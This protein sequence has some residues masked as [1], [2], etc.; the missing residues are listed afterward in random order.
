MEIG[1]LAFGYRNRNGE[2]RESFALFGSENSAAARYA[3]KNG[4]PFEPVEIDEASILEHLRENPAEGGAEARLSY[5]MVFGDRCLARVVLTANG[6]S[7]S[8]LGW[9]WLGVENIKSFKVDDYQ[10]WG[11]A[12][13]LRP[14]SKGQYNV[15]ELDDNGN[16]IISFCG[17]M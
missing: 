1:D 10:R 5:F 15:L 13:F 12:E 6:Q 17:G 9:I 3:D 16:M 8:G 2:K 11:W 14:I 4:L 7:F